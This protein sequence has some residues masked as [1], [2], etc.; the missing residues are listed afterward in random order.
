MKLSGLPPPVRIRVELSQM[1]QPLLSRSVRT[2][3]PS[4]FWMV[5]IS[6][7][8]NSPLRGAADQKRQHEIVFVDFQASPQL[9]GREGV[10]NAVKSAF[11]APSLRMPAKENGGRRRSQPSMTNSTRILT[12]GDLARRIVGVTNNQVVRLWPAAF[13]SVAKLSFLPCGRKYLTRWQKQPIMLV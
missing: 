10:L 12:G 6:S 5:S 11:S 1:R 3:F 4:R 9:V 2:H 8:A 13:L 7:S